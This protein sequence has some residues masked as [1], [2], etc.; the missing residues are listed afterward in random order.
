MFPKTAQCLI[1]PSKRREGSLRCSCRTL[2]LLILLF[3]AI[4]SIA[5]SA[6]KGP[7]EPSVTTEPP[8]LVVSSHPVASEA[9]LE[10][11]RR[12]G[13]AVD[14]AVATGLA[15]GVVDP[16]NSGIGGGGFVIAR[17]NDGRVFAID[18][19]ET[20]PAA[21]SRGMF[22][23]D[24]KYD[25][26]L[27]R[28]GPLAVAVPGL[29]AAYVKALE[30]AGSRPLGELI[31]PSIEL[32]EKGF[33]LDAYALA[34]YGEAIEALRRDP[35]SERI[36]LHADGSL[37]EEGEIFRQ[38]DLAGTYR[39][40]A[41]E[42]AEYFYLGEFARRLADY[43]SNRGGLISLSDM[44][45]YRA[46]LREP[47]VGT[48]REYT[49]VG[50]P[51]PSSGGVN[52]LQIL[53]LLEVSGILEGKSNWDEDS[54]LGTA[55][56]M[57]AAFR[58]R[59]TYLGDSDFYPVPVRRLTGKAYAEE[60][61]AGLPDGASP[62]GSEAG[63]DALPEGGHTTAYVVLDRDG[64][65]VVVNQTINLNYGAKITLPG[66]GVLLNN[67]M[68]DFSAS[69]GEPNA[70]GLVGSE[71]NAIEPGKRPLSSMSPTLIVRDSRPVMALGGSGG[72]TIITSVLQ[73]VVDVL[74]FR[75]DLAEAMSLSR[76]H[77]QYL[78]DVLMV[79]PNTPMAV[80]PGGRWKG[81]K[82][83]VRD[84]IG[85]LN[86]IAWNGRERI[87]AGVSD[88]RARGSRASF[89]LPEDGH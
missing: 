44:S 35:A 58:D 48:Y 66:T 6:A 40:I 80:Q 34:R 33:V 71:A 17:L 47:V 26:S 30:L 2:F 19:R 60:V 10:I 85:V 21:S 7:P 9:G 59:A 64:N 57:S 83:V 50:M 52:V 15:L 8:G 27:S 56:F 81:E 31:Q 75:M 84:H 5:C 63:D 11:L 51:P 68:D 53:N 54:I 22:V 72:P 77:D 70:F 12:G 78:P 1:T 73:V 36:Y 45:G 46:V 41:A 29:L 16:F 62:T 88:P 28:E 18:G 25:A 82:V 69:P 61:L 89:Q 76:F 23:R 39:K 74:D 65:V 49:V 3:A 14:G 55:R 24:G 20:A 4:V 43:M 32:A 37:F 87:Y 86:A 42:G 13:N 38:P 67:E 79:E